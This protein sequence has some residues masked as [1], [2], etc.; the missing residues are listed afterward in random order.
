M[1]DSRTYIKWRDRTKE[2]HKDYFRKW[3]KDHKE[4]LREYYKNWHKQNPDYEKN[5]RLQ[6][7]Y[8]IDLETYSDL[9]AAQG[10]ECAI[11]GIHADLFE[12]ALAVDHNHETGKVRGLLCHNCN[13][14]LGSFKDDVARLQK[15]VQYLV[16]NGEL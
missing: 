11:C 16:R 2:E 5:R 8:G 1:A 3:R 4:Q 13:L 12:R 6:S 15:A 7:C 10:G 9:F 14:A